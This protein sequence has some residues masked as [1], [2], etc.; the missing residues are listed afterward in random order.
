MAAY[1]LGKERGDLSPEMLERCA[2]VV[3]IPTKFC[4]NLSVDGRDCA[5]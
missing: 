1:V 2:H 3:K 4:V 5:L